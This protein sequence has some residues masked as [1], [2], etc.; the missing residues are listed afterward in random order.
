MRGAWLLA[1]GLFVAT[2]AAAAEDSE[3][4]FADCDGCPEMIV[5]PGGTFQMGTDTGPESERPAH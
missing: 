1:C 5:V 4:A 2:A 3:S